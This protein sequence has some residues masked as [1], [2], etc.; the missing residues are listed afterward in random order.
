MLSPF[1]SLGSQ[2]APQIT[3]DQSKCTT[4]MTCR[5]CLEICPQAVFMVK[6]VKIVKYVETDIHE[7]SAYRVRPL[8]RDKCVVCDDCL[9]VCPV[10]AITI[11]LPEGV[12]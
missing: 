11:M 6:V 8:F 7:P 5:K 10:G 1:D 2:L 3:V 4:P 12:Q 9:A